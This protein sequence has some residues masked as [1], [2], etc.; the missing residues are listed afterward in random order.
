MNAVMNIVMNIITHT[1]GQT[2]RQSD[3]L[4]SY[5]SQQ[6]NHLIINQTLKGDLKSLKIRQQ[7]GL[8]NIECISPAFNWCYQTQYLGSDLNHQILYHQLQLCQEL[9][10][11]IGKT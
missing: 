8:V 11:G 2:D 3:F 9:S 5:R 6:F 4:S 7:I 10:G 1:K